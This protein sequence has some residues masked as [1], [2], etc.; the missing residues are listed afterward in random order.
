MTTSFL[1]AE[2]ISAPRTQVCIFQ[3][4]LVQ[5]MIDNNYFIVKILKGKNCQFSLYPRQ[6]LPIHVHCLIIFEQTLG[7]K[8]KYNIRFLL[9]RNCR[10]PK[11]RKNH[12]LTA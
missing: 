11:K 12:I 4:F 3:S 10:K 9:P 7:T 6:N 1:N 8:E 5:I 2:T